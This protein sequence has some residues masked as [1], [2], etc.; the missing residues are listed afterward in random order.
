MDSHIDRLTAACGLRHFSYRAFGAPEI[1]IVQRLPEPEPELDV[2]AIPEAEAMV[3]SPEP[4]AE[5]PI[6]ARPPVPIQPPAS[7]PPIRLA[8]PPEEQE[9][10]MALPVR[11]APVV[12]P[13][14]DAPV[15]AAVARPS[16]PVPSG[17]PPVVLPDPDAFDPIIAFRGR[18]ARGSPDRRAAPPVP[19]A[20]RRDAP[21]PPRRDTPPRRFALLDEIAPPA[22][23]PP[24]PSD[25]RMPPPASPGRP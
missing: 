22:G 13:P 18:D 6:A 12:L 21:D 16:R 14:P 3:A 9:A 24:V 5:A 10:G 8:E 23:R 19:P 4:P 2:A 20:P 7:A 25:R 17:R 1:V 15:I 11:R